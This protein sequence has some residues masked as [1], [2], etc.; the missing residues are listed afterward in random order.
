MRGAWIFVLAGIA[1]ACGEAASN[2]STTLGT[3]PTPI[4]ASA[5][6]N[7]CPHDAP[8]G[9]RVGTFGLRV[10][11]DW[12][13]VPNITDYQIE[14][15]RYEF[16]NAYAGAGMFI[17]QNATHADWYGRRDSKYRARLRTRTACGDFGD[18]TGYLT[19]AIDADAK[20][21]TAP[22]PPEEECGPRPT[23]LMPAD[24][25]E[26]DGACPPEPPACRSEQ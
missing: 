20:G 6:E 1:A 18:W 15:D 23:S 10:D 25:C 19:F 4:L 2:P 13:A 7:S 9:F 14:I 17:T 12:N 16:S 22:T 3:A 5:A 8:A 24:P 26:E 11:F 21:P